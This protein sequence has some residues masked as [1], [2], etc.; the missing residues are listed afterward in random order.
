MAEIIAD[1]LHRQALVKEVLRRRV[2]K[3][4]RTAALADD[5]EEVEVAADNVPRSRPGLSVGSGH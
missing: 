1:L 5:P 2:A 3:R 4:V